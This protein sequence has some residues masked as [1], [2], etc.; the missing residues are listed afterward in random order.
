MEMELAGLFFIADNDDLLSFNSSPNTSWIRDGAY[1]I[2]NNGSLMVKNV[3][4]ELV[5]R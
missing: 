1:H 4:R 3:R 5:E 2:L